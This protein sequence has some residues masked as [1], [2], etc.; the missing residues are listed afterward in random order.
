MKATGK[1]GIKMKP[2]H[3]WLTTT[4]NISY[5]TVKIV[6]HLRWFKKV[7]YNRQSHNWDTTAYSQSPLQ[8]YINVRLKKNWIYDIFLGK[9]DKYNS[10]SHLSD[11]FFFPSRANNRLWYDSQVSFD[12]SK[13]FMFE[14]F[15]EMK[16]AN[17]KE[18]KKKDHTSW[19]IFPQ[20]W[21]NYLEWLMT[22]SF[23]SDS[24]DSVLSR[25]IYHA[26]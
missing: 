14:I 9:S 18:K 24:R 8:F 26:Q 25:T 19:Y 3:K 15:W 22:Y 4:N 17:P 11:P 6:V 1:C 16:K 23:L 12:N 21:N 2:S 5:W 20:K 13:F 7:S 10:F